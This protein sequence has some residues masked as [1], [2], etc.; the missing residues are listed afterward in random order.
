MEDVAGE[1][2]RVDADENILAA[3][4]LALDE[5]DVVLAG[6][7]LAE[8]DR[9]ELAVLRR[10]PHRAHAL[11]ELLRAAAVLDEVGDG[12]ELQ[13][14]PLAVADEIGDARHRPVVVHDLADDAARLEAG[15]PCEV[16]GRLGLAGALENAA[17]P[18]AERLDVPALDEVLRP[19]RRVD[20]AEDRVRA[21][22]CRDAGRDPFSCVDGIRVRRPVP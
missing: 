6:E 13:A 14:V 8:R 17:G 15:E 5:R 12:D 9:R 18:G 16:D 21:V 2:L 11:D 7:G 22:G 4:D 1:A 10:Q 20:R 19:G 3:G